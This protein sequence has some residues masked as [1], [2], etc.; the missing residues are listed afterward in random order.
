[1][2]IGDSRSQGIAE[3]LAVLTAIRLWKS[4]LAERPIA[5]QVR[6][7][8]TTALAMLNKLAS[9]S[10]SLNYL[11]AELALTLE[12]TLV[13]C[14][15]GTRTLMFINIYIYIYIVMYVFLNFVLIPSPFRISIPRG[16]AIG[17]GLR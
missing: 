9:S 11:G 13:E 5:L 12:D 6:S 16:Y 1:M 7:D 17:S 4:K 14:I 10:P 15:E 8:S 2:I 3:A